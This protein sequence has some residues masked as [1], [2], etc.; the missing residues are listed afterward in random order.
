[1]SAGQLVP[2]DLIVGIIRERLQAADCRGG[3]LLDG[4]PRTIAQ[5]EALDAMLAAEARR[6]TW[7]WNCRCRKKRCSSGWPA[8]AAPTTSPR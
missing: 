8:A 6:W 7:C 4:F 1:M 2:D 3:Y 5:A